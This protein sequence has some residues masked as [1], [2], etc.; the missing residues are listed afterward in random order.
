MNGTFTSKQCSTHN[1]FILQVLLAIVT[2]MSR[3]PSLMAIS[4]RSAKE[5]RW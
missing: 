1:L 4:T 2:A 5:E 3:K